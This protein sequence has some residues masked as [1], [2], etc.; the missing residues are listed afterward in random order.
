MR[1]GQ[2]VNGDLGQLLERASPDD[3]RLLFIE[4]KAVAGHPVTDP[5]HAAG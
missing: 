2:R 3:L 5:D 4:F 1:Q